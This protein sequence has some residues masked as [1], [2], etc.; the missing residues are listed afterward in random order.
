MKR[1]TSLLAGA[2]AAAAM[3]VGAV[4]PAAAQADTIEIGVI[5]PM[6]G[7]NAVQGKDIVQGIKLAVE[8]VNNGYDVPMM[9]GS[10]VTVGPDD[11]GGKIKLIVEDTESRPA[12]ALAAVRKL[13]NA[14]KVP[15]VLGVLSSGICVPTGNFT[16]ENKVVQI[17]A[18][19]TSPKL[20][21]YG[22]YFFDVMGLDNLMG[23][24]LGEF[25]YDDTGGAKKYASFVA[26]NPFGVGMEIQ[27]CKKIEELGGE[28]VTKVRYRQGKS[29][30]RADLRRVMDKD[31]DAIMYTAYGTDAR[32][33]LKQA[34]ELGIDV[35]KNWYADY[36][37]LWI[38]EISETPQIGEGIKGTRAGVYDDFYND[39]YAEAYEKAFGETP[40]TAFGGYAYD[41]AM[42]IA[43]AI[44][45]AGASTSDAIKDALRPVSVDY[46]GVS[47]NKK[48]D[49]DGMQVNERYAR[50]IVK[51]GKLEPYEDD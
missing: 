41:S 47:G 28:C 46:R 43:L 31:P 37:T 44:K 27:G 30:Y 21:D 39:V 38:N 2:A 13:V 32:L 45:K 33:I 12:S 42:L 23:Q 26:N 50:L 1:F 5:A 3:C 17:A 4:L 19:C 29:D 10:T 40:S 24:A 48:F 25:A 20:R 11:M 49:E 36:P 15:V 14:D 8:R 16:N 18:A 9:D 34:Y 22:P 51:D 6:T 7:R 35:S